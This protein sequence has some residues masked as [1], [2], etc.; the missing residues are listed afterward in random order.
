MNFH[1]HSG[2]GFLTAGGHKGVKD[3][4]EDGA[5][6]VPDGPVSKASLPGGL[7]P[8]EDAV[9]TGSERNADAVDDDHAAAAP[10]GV[11]SVTFESALTS[12]FNRT[13]EEFGKADNAALVGTTAVVTLVGSR[14]LY[15]ANCG[16]SPPIDSGPF[17][18]WCRVRAAA[19]LMTVV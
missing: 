11:N 3:G 16:P 14:Q 15:V 2:L 5:D 18:L 10:D 17:T 12:A 9:D 6:G 19:A 8:V 13:D 4:T 1:F 7:R